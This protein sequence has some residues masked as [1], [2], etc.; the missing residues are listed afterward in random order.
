MTT[1]PATPG[2]RAHG[3]HPRSAPPGPAARSRSGGRTASARRARPGTRVGRSVPGVTRLSPWQPSDTDAVLALI[4]DVAAR[5]ITPRFRSLA[6]GEVMEKNPGDLVTV[7]D[8]E[9]EALLTEALVRGIPRRGRPRRGDLRRRPSLLD[10]YLAADH[11]FTVD[12]STGRR[13]SSTA[14]P[15]T[16]SWSPRPSAAR[17]SGPGSGSPSTGSAGSPSAAPAST[18]TASGC[19]ASPSPTASRRRGDVD[20]DAARPCARRARADAAHLGLL[21]RR[22]PQAHRGRGRLPRLQPLQGVG[23][24]ARRAHGDRGRRPGRA[25]RRQRLHA[26]LDPSRAL[27]AADPA[28]Y[29]AVQRRAHGAFERP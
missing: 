10:R 7:A 18:A 29:A 14:R 6:E 22:L 4:Q 2:G 5:V 28:T 16:P 17:R 21:R 8:R 3:S 20:V 9:A 11:A 15:T 1:G 27:V 13:T 12:P 26:A 24:R 23:P 25:P 19:T